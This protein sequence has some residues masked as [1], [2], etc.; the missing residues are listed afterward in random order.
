MLVTKKHRT[1]TRGHLT[2]SDSDDGTQ[3]I[4]LH[5][6]FPH[7]T[8]GKYLFLLMC[9]AGVELFRTEIVHVLGT[10]ILRNHGGT[11]NKQGLSR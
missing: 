10:E 11:L 1:S 2:Y 4:G 6:L 9:P 8:R 7:V 3:V 5:L